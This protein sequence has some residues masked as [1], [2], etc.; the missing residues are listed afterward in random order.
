MSSKQLH[1]LKDLVIF[2]EDHKI[3]TNIS[4]KEAELKVDDDVLL[5]KHIARCWN[6]IN[7]ARLTQEFKKQNPSDTYFVGLRNKPYSAK[8]VPFSRKKAVRSDG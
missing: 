1:Y 2:C 4:L 7:M 3:K 6:Y 8:P 5:S